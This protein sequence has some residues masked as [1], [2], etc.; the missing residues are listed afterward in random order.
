MFPVM[1]SMYILRKDLAAAGIPFKDTLGRQ[2]DFHALGI[3]LAPTCR[4]RALC[5]GWRWN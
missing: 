5:L 4:W 1:P 2:A 3:L